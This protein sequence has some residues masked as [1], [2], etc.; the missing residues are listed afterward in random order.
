MSRPLAALLLV[1]VIT[2]AC[3]Q[4]RQVWF[5]GPF[6]VGT[7][8][9]S[10]L[11]EV[12]GV[13]SSVHSPGL[14]WMHN[15]SGDEPRIFALTSQGRIVAEVKLQ[16]AKHIDWEDI[17]RGPGPVQGK[18]Y[19]YIA[20]IGDNSARRSEVTI[21]RIREPLLDT[22][23]RDI[24]RVVAADSVERFTL[25]YPDG[26]R[27]AE[28]LLVE[29]RSGE[30]VIV[31]KRENRCRVYST[32][33]L[34]ASGGSVVLSYVGDLPL[35]LVTGGDVSPDGSMVVLKTY[36]HVRLWTRLPGSSLAATITGAGTPLP[37]MPERQGEAI[38]FTS[39]GDG[40]YTTSECENGGPSSAIMLY[41]SAPDETRA[42]Q[43]RDVRLP[44]ISVGRIVP[45]GTTYRVRYSVP[46]LE[47]VSLTV[48]NAAMFRVMTLAEDSAESGPQER[49]FD[50]SKLPPGSYSV[51][52][53][54]A[55]A[56]VSALLEIR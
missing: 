56:R 13:V 29:P 43:L 44:S 49:D 17:A 34:P 1:I 27:D 23:Q 28:A 54:S 41:P 53:E 55:S 40:Y 12:S 38:G 22:A 30:L 3:A 21:Y 6:R 50:A 32:S 10:T 15:D 48:H 39:N 19:L 36:L 46:E 5:G 18:S 45:S 42:R 8:P 2:S 11:S 51:V 20:D 14:L 9:I 7:T 37:Y 31:T 16:G 33:A 4:D 24:R 35:Q 47:R 52:L 25:H 26:S